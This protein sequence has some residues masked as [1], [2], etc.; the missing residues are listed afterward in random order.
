MANKRED[1]P[2]PSARAVRALPA[3]AA[4]RRGP[5]PPPS[6]DP[7]AGTPTAP[8]PRA[9]PPPPQLPPDP[10]L[11]QLRRE[12]QPKEKLNLRLP[13]PVKNTMWTF[14]GNEGLANKIGDLM[15]IAIQEYLQEQGYEIPGVPPVTVPEVPKVAPRGLDGYIFS[16]TVDGS[17]PEVAVLVQRNTDRVGINVHVLKA[18]LDVLEQFRT[19]IRVDTKQ[20]GDLVSLAVQCFLE[21]RGVMAPDMRRVL[22]WPDLDEVDEGPDNDSDDS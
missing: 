21:R 18:I 8:G 19:D 14:A 22:P 2:I 17:D 5:A 10:L 4:T 13:V 3:D 11:E 12:N 7:I 1:L 15:G 20:K 9:V 16:E 6:D